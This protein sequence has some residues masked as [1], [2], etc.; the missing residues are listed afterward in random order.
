MVGISAMKELMRA[1]V[2]LNILWTLFKV[3]TCDEEN[4]S[5]RCSD[6]QPYT[7]RSTTVH[8]REESFSPVEHLPLTIS[9]DQCAFA[10]NFLENTRSAL[11]FS[12]LSSM[13]AKNEREWSVEKEGKGTRLGTQFDE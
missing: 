4:K 11:L 13:A 2:V 1:F 12:D 8:V 3:V 10:E 9:T 7:L 5:W 6:D